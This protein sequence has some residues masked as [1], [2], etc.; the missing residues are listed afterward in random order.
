MKYGNLILT[1]ITPQTV[2]DYPNERT[3]RCH[4]CDV[5]YIWPQKIGSLKTMTCPTCGG[6][7][8]Q[9]TH[10]FKGKTVRITMEVKKDVKNSF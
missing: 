2:P 3:G 6:P 10:L 8:S 4:H 7:M 1:E 9:T 5:R